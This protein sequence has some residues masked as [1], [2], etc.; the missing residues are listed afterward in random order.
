MKKHRDH[1]LNICISY[2]NSIHESK[3]SI[4][5]KTEKSNFNV[6]YCKIIPQ[7][8][9]EQIK[10]GSFLKFEVRLSGNFPIIDIPYSMVYDHTKWL[11]SG[12][13]NGYSKVNTYHYLV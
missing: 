11:L 13:Y 8:N 4:S 12:S 9:L 1:A 3:K 10:I 2:A 7:F 5:F 6:L